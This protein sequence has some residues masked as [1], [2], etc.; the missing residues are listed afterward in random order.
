MNCKFSQFWH[1]SKKFEQQTLIN[2]IRSIKIF[3]NYN[4]IYLKE[5]F[6]YDPKVR[7][8]YWVKAKTVGYAG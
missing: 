2:I 3:F 5:T 1:L 4:K 8:V 7:F 6:I